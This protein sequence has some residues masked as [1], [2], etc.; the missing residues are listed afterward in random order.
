[1]RLS[2]IA[3]RLGCEFEGDGSIEITGVAGLEEAGDGDITFLSNPKY[4]AKISDTTASAII[5]STNF[6]NTTD[7]RLPLLRN[8]NPYLT[9]ARAIE[10]FYTPPPAPEGVHPSAVVSNSAK[11]GQNV[12][13]GANSVIG[14]DVE[15]GDDVT[16]YPNCTIYAKAPKCESAK[17]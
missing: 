17:R 9:F 6:Q 7:R 14:D 8:P 3:A 13:I 1:M 5:V 10:L 2:E 16:I 4:T 15:I 12:R 11:L